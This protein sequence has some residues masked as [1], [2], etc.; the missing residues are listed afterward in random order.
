MTLEATEGMKS[1][2]TTKNTDISIN[3]AWRAL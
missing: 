2:Y 3:L 1:E